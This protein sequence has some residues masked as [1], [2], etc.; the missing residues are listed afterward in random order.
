[1][2]E[3]IK[4]ANGVSYDLSKISSVNNNLTFSIKDVDKVELEKLLKDTSNVK[5][6]KLISKS[7]ETQDE[8]LI[9]AY[10]GYVNLSIMK[11]EYGIV[12]NIDYSTQDETTESG[13]A[14]EKHDITTVILIKP[15]KTEA[16]LAAIRE[17]QVLQ[18]GA[19]E[20]MASMLSNI[21]E[22]QELQDGAIE[23]IAIVVSEIAEES[24][25][26]A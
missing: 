11:T 5:I 19:I 20:E 9:K 4:F 7:E 2:K 14:E 22:G 8:T 16:E 23:D 3:Q 10:A 12:T 25:A 26:G 15:S 24:E 1:M 17:S 6:I 13:F 21:S 18:D